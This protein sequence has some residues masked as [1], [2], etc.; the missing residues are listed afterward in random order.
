MPVPFQIELH[1]PDYYIIIVSG[2]IY[3]VVLQPWLAKAQENK[4]EC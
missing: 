2:P 3:P 1:S 4:N